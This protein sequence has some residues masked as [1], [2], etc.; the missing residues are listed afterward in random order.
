MLKSLI[1]SRRAR[2]TVALIA[3][4]WDRLRGRCDPL[5][6]PRRFAVFIGAGDFRQMGEDFSRFFIELG[7]LRPDDDVL[8]IG[9]GIGRMAVPLLDYLSGR[10]EGFD[11][12]P[13]GVAW[14]QE[15]ISSRYPNFR[16]E[17]ADIENGLYR[18]NGRYQAC[19][20]RFPYDDAS[21]DFAF[22]TSVFTHLIP[23][24]AANYINETGRTLREGKTLFATFFLLDDHPASDETTL[25]FRVAGDG[26]RTISAATPEAAVAYTREDV[27][28]MLTSAGMTLVSVFPGSW[29][30]REDGLSYQDVVVAKKRASR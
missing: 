7:G 6:P 13:S 3:D 16:F 26:F 23:E 21:F 29:S 25:D 28:K 27:E 11:I 10:Y 14:C 20:Y 24:D 22:A 4:V 12:V 15:H 5:S 2:F 19:E 8:D 1:T 9:S 17:L 30:G 18:Q